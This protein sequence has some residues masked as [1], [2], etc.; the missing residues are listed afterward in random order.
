MRSVSDEDPGVPGDGEHDSQIARLF[1]EPLSE[2]D[3][4]VCEDC[5]QDYIVSQKS[6]RGRSSVP[7]CPH[8]SV[9]VEEHLESQAKLAR[10]KS[11][12]GWDSVSPEAKRWWEAF[13]FNYKHEIDVVLKVAIEL[14]GLNSTVDNLY[15]AYVQSGTS[16]VA[17]NLHF[18]EYLRMKQSG[19]GPLPPVRKAKA[20]TSSVK[21]M[22]ST[23]AQNGVAVILVSFGV[24]KIDVAKKIKEM[25][26]LPLV[27]CK[28]LVERAPTIIGRCESNADANA[29]ADAIIAL[30]GLARVE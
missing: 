2:G 7:Q 3:A 26:H 21:P 18:M 16:N 24:K 6:G 14:E 22:I 15:D 19:N 9:T 20:A 25:T 13:E 29:A 28:Q 30:G 11:N 5:H 27:T 12:I 1:W 23:T 8:C 17:A 4:A 10:A